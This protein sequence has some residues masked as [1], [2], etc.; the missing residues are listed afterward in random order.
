MCFSIHV[1]LVFLFD[2]ANFLKTDSSRAHLGF[3][4][5]CYKK[6]IVVIVMFLRTNKI[7]SLNRFCFCQFFFLS[8]HNHSYK[9]MEMGACKLEV[10]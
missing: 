9:H 3:N 2:F 7:F 10:F 5:L 4:L 1:N 6:N 8:I